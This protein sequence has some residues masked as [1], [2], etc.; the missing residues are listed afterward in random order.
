[1]AP[2]LKSKTLL[3]LL[4]GFALVYAVVVLLALQTTTFPAPPDIPFLPTG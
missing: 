3:F 2:R 4:F 1:M